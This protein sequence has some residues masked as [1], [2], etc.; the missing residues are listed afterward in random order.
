[1]ILKL[2]NYLKLNKINY[3]L[4]YCVNNK[5]NSNLPS[6]PVYFVGGVEKI[7]LDEFGIKYPIYPMSFLQ[8]NNGVKSK[9]YTHILSL[10]DGDSTILDAYSGAGLLSACMAKKSKHVFAVEIDKSANQACVDLCELNKIK[11]LTAICGDVGAVVPTLVKENKVDIIVLDPARKGVDEETLNSIVSAKPKKVIYLSCNPATL[12]R[13]LAIL[14]SRDYKIEFIQPY[15][16]FPQT[17]EVETLVLLE[18]K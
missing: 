3:S 14:C 7:I 17:S 11:N 8:V 6:Y 4:H 5:Q 12:V 10:V 2:E 9:I 1:M 16:M 15:D 18:H 13:D